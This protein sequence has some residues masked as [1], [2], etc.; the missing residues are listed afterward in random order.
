[1]LFSLEKASDCGGKPKTISVAN[2]ESLLRLID[3]YKHDIV[4][5][6][7]YEPNAEK[8]EW[9]KDLEPYTIII[10]DDYLE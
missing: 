7:N 10:Y 9:A 8:P 2:L 1:M 6:A 5:Q 3:D 4:I